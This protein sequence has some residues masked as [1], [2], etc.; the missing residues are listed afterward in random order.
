MPSPA[1]RPVQVETVQLIAAHALLVVE[2]FDDA[3]SLTLARCASSNVE[4][5]SVI[6]PSKC[7]DPLR[8]QLRL[9]YFWRVSS[10]I[11]LRGPECHHGFPRPLLSETCS[12]PEAK[13]HGSGQWADITGHTA[14]SLLCTLGRG[15]LWQTAQQ[16]LR[17]RSCSNDNAHLPQEEVQFL[18]LVPSDCS[19]TK[20]AARCNAGQHENQVAVRLSS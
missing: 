5:S 11:T 18:Q 19:T 3:S 7:L 1:R 14:S 9:R 4:T 10:D 16:A 8:Q 2:E 20:Q 6:H 12:P 13:H 17:I 15:L